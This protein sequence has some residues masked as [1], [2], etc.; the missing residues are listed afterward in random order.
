MSQNNIFE[1]IK[2]VNKKSKEAF[3]VV[4]TSSLKDR[5][6]AILNTSK[7]IKK[8]REEILKANKTDIENAKRKQLSNAFIDRLLLDDKRID[9]IVKGLQEIS[10][11]NDPIGVELSRWTQPNGLNISRVSV[12]LGIIGIIYESRPNVTIDAGSLCIK[13][14]NTA[15]LRGGSDSINSSKILAKCMQK[16]LESANL[17]GDTI[18]IVKNTNREAVSAMLTSTGEIDIII[19]RGGKSLVKKIQDE[20]RVPVFAHLEGI[21]HIYVDK[22][23]NINKAIKIILNS[24]MRRTGICGALETLLIDREISKIA[25]PILVEKLIESGCHIRGDIETK[26]IVN[27]IELASEKDWYTEYLDAILS[28][29]IVNGVSGAID[30]ISKYSSNHTESIITE[31][32]TVAETFLSTVDS[33]IVMHNT[34]TQFADGGEFGMGAEIGISTGRIHARGPVGAAQLTSFKYIV[35]GNDQIRE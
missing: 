7:I 3:N 28:I 13:S 6:L 19:P 26:N 11:M 29:K 30:H 31:N 35:R 24:K 1:Y 8:E 17:P 23:A 15:I 4:S 22:D 34:S 27:K 21:C 32:V 2:L 16:G 33:S 25:V 9:D 5:N 18:Q 14:G 20:A 10:E 12:P